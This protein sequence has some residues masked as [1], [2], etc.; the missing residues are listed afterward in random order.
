MPVAPVRLAPLA[1]ALGFVFDAHAQSTVASDRAHDAAELPTPAGAER[2]RTLDQIT[3]TAQALGSTLDTRTETASRLGLTPRQTPAT[4]DVLTQAQM[5]ERG[6]RNSIEALNAVPGVTSPNLSSVTSSSVASMRGFSGGAISV[7]FDGMRQTA[8]SLVTRNL[9]SWGF[10]SIEV[11]KGPASVLYGEGA[12]AGAINLVPKRAQLDESTFSGLV[13][14]GSFDSYRVAVDAN[15]PVTPE[16]G[17]RAVASHSRSDG[18][19]DD[20]ASRI[21]AASLSAR[22]QPDERLTVDVALDHFRDDYTTPYFGTPLVP[23]EVA[24]EPSDL[25]STTDGRVLDEA[26]REAN[27]NVEDGLED[28][29]SNWL[30]SRVSWQAD[31]TWRLTNELSYYDAERRWINAETYTFNSD[32]GLLDRSSTRIEH[33]HQYWIERATLVADGSLGGHRNRFAAGFEYE[34]NDFFSL[35]RFGTLPS[36][37]PYAPV[38]GQF[39]T[40]DSETN[41][42][43]E[44]NRDN[45]DSGTEGAAVFV[46]DAINLTPRWLLIGGLR[47]EQIE[48]ERTIDDLNA[49]TRTHFTQEFSPLS[50]RLGSVFELAPK[51]QLYAQASHAVTPVSSL[52]V[53]SLANSSFDLTEGETLEAGVKTTL[54]NDRLDLTAAAYWLRQD[55]IITRDEHNTALS[56]QGGEQSSR[57]VEVS[58]SARLTEALRVDANLAVLDARFDSLLDAEGVSLA[59]N[60]PPHV[61]ERVGNLFAVYRRRE[62]PWTFS[63]GLRYAGPFFTDNANTIRVAGHALLDASIGYRL[64]PGELTVRGRNLTDR[65][66]ADWSGG[67]PDQIVLGAPRSVELSWTV[68]L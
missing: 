52:L 6:I 55:E 65:L 1:L 31:D 21:S 17:L 42:P 54:W 61:S 44:G 30:R 62:S 58:A 39:P 2:A 15:I 13:S 25:V 51:T 16:F 37:D 5:Q 26:L 19:I 23:A 27:F 9:D 53:I 35:R 48:L 24:R 66:Y 63:A 28:S 7:L 8:A 41:F 3:V 22:W 36:L 60:V 33:D 18:Y 67:A 11:L 47:Y 12:L 4:I 14:A 32:T 46:E 40:E 59:G 45:F 34:V 43:G 29:R 50:W 56:V 64:G 38:R 10:E 20:T 57:G 68:A 49:G